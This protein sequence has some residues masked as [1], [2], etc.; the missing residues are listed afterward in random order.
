MYIN[1][2]FLNTPKPY[3]EE[4]SME[5]KDRRKFSLVSKQETK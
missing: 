3:E 1:L 4:S 2:S 5:M